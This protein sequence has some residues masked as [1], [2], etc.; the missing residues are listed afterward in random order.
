M[1]PEEREHL[2]E[3]LI[4]ADDRHT[5]FGVDLMQRWEQLTGEM[6]GWDPDAYFTPLENVLHR[7][8]EFAGYDYHRDISRP[9]YEQRLIKDANRI[10]PEKTKELIEKHKALNPELDSKEDKE[11]L[12]DLYNISNPPS[13]DEEITS[14]TK[15]TF[16][17]YGYSDDSAYI[18]YDSEDC[19][20]R[21][22]IADVGNEKEGILMTFAYVG[23]WVVGIGPRDED[24]PIPDWA[25]HPEYTAKD[26]TAVVSFEAPIDTKVTWKRFDFENCRW[27]ASE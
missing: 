23:T 3:L 27:E 11:Y 17:C 26:Y 5:M 19:F 15:K 22:A 8:A 13:T 12:N 16:K 25:K 21:I 4:E 14:Y 18:N 24:L 2:R 6:L 9:S 10:D 20:G 1:T 7:I